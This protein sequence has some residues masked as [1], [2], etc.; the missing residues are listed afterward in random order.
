[1]TIRTGLFRYVAHQDAESYLKLGWVNTLALHDCHH[2][3]YSDLY[4]WPCECPPVEPSPQPIEFH[5]RTP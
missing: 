3:Q 2:G 4:H 1:M 5:G